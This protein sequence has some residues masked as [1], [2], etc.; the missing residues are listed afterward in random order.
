MNGAIPQLIIWTCWEDVQV[1]SAS[2][3][4]PQAS[5]QRL[6]DFFV[7]LVCCKPVLNPLVNDHR[8][9]VIAPME[10]ADQIEVI[11]MP[12]VVRSNRGPQK[13][14]PLWVDHGRKRG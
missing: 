9:L 10:L 14:R 11:L 4:Q 12:T 5:L 1:E 13:H 8:R 2:I 6:E 7:D 3:V